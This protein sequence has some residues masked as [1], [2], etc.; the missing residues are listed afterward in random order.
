MSAITDIAL[1]TASSATK[2]AILP[3]L[4]LAGVMALGASGASGMYAGYEI[5]TARHAD[6]QKKLLQASADTADALK[7]A[8]KE[9]RQ[10]G[11]DATGVF[12]EELRGMRVVNTTI[13]KEVQ[14]EVQKL[15]YTD[16]VLPDSGVELLQRHVDMVNMRLLESDKK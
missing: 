7:E 10:R 12:L 6:D 11:D 15:V 3:W 1:G 13:N 5:A 14:T 2:K 9:A 16:C 8:L 4:I